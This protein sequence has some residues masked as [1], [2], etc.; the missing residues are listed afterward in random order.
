[1][2][3]KPRRLP[4]RFPT[5]P[6]PIPIQ[7]ITRCHPPLLCPHSLLLSHWSNAVLSCLKVAAASSL[8]AAGSPPLP[9]ADAG[10]AGWTLLLRNLYK[11][12]FSLLC[13]FGTLVQPTVSC[14]IWPRHLIFICSLR[15]IVCSLFALHIQVQFFSEESFP[16]FPN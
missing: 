10:S 12:G 6:I 16:N 13:G 1:M 5:F 9:T 2:R 15:K 14:V 4:W 7:S 11:S 8:S 3:H